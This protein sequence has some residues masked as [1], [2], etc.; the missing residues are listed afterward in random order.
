MEHILWVK[1]SLNVK[2]N[3][4][5]AWS[6]KELQSSDLFIYNIQLHVQAPCSVFK[7]ATDWWQKLEVSVYG[8]KHVKQE[9]KETRK[10]M[11]A[12]EER[13]GETKRMV[14]VSTE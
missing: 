1:G 9:R 5:D 12:E 3:K 14:N 2:P 8:L 7:T 10:A 13:A 4:W 11:C 6:Y